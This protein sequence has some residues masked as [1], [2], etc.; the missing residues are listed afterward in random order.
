MLNS[1]VESKAREERYDL[2]KQVVIQNEITH[3]LFGHHQT[4]NIETFLMRYLYLWLYRLYRCSGLVGLNSIQ[5][6]RRFT[7]NCH[8]LRP[9]LCYSKKEILNYCSTHDIPFYI[10]ES[11][12]DLKYDRNRV[13]YII[14]QYGD[15]LHKDIS[16]MITIINKV[17]E[18]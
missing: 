13:R 17:F 14:N 5:S 8:I 3:L 10:D 18:I 15:D 12:T 2:L 6:N 11:N 1:K 4:D 7:K 9:L 16:L